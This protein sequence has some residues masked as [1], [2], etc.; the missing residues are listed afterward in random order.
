MRK[1]GR[2]RGHLRVL[3]YCKN[4][5]MGAVSWRGKKKGLMYRHA[6]SIMAQMLCK[7]RIKPLRLHYVRSGAIQNTGIQEF[8]AD[9]MLLNDFFR[10]RGIYVAVNYGGHTGND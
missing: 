9:Y 5:H 2:Y 4:A 8:L 6:D 1:A 10:D 7:N 3:H